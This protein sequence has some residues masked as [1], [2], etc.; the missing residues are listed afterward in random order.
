MPGSLGEHFYIFIFIL[1]HSKNVV[2]FKIV[3][4][5]VINYY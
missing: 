4:E 5:F 1:Y 3:I 2:T